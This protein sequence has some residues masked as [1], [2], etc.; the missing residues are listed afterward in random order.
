MGMYALLW[1]SSSALIWCGS[2]RTTILGS[3]V[4]GGAVCGVVYS[5][6]QIIG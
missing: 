4:M 1:F 2:T 5:L 3:I 6:T